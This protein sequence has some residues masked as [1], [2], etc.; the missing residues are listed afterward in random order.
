MQG[1]P[2][3]VS[4]LVAISRDRLIASTRLVLA[5]AGFV[6][7]YLDTGEPRTG[8]T[9]VYGLL[10]LYIALAL[11]CLLLVKRSLKARTVYAIHIAEVALIAVLAATTAGAASPFFV[12][13]TFVMFIAT[14]RWEWRGAIATGLFLCAVLFAMST[15]SVLTGSA[16]QEIDRVV[17]RSIWLPVAAVLFA[18]VGAYFAYSR[19][20]LADLATWPYVQASSGEFPPL[21]PLLEH[22]A[23]VL[24]ARRA[25]AI[26]AWAD[27]PFAFFCCWANGQCE[28]DRFPPGFADELLPAAGG[29][30]S[31]FWPQD[32]SE[33][34]TRGFG[35]AYRRLAERFG[36][37]QA[38]TSAFQQTNCEGR[39]FFL[40]M[41]NHSE[42]E[43]RLSEIAA[44]RIGTE[45]DSHY[46]QLQHSRDIRYKERLRLT[47]D[48]HD[49]V[50]QSLTAVAMKLDDVTGSVSQQARQPL[51]S[52]HEIVI[53]E[54]QRIRTFVDRARESEDTR[55]FICLLAA[56]NEL[57]DS[58]QQLWNC[59]IEIQVSPPDIELDRHSYEQVRFL[60]Q[61]SL[62]NAVRHGG[63]SQVRWTF[64]FLPYE[65][66]IHLTNNGRKIPESYKESAKPRSLSRRVAQLDGR[67]NISNSPDGVAIEITFPA[68]ASGMQWQRP[69]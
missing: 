28:Y 26:W 45:I 47:H 14:L 52:L 30:D 68:G 42:E 57:T 40:E 33:G 66:Q 62:A 32:N 49:N 23:Q 53:A 35:S 17:L 22:A 25:V 37:E 50:L 67:F 5:L 58:Q 39:C 54:H 43:L 44:F 29:A 4:N 31:F 27:E 1:V 41:Q 55:S 15:A 19:K 61:E 3:F 69:A 9:V 13:F 59:A 7:F 2:D 56:L 16:P 36:I 8:S 20:R 34:E 46:L 11:V 21:G 38:V 65:M 60:L 48:L 63:A 64:R 6:A 24:G 10:G 12:L 18:Y 51:L